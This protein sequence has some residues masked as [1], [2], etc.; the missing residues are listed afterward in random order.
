M[1]AFELAIAQGADGIELDVQRTRDGQLVVIHDETVD[2]TSTG[3]GKV[4]DLTLDELRAF[5]Y[6]NG[7]SGF[8]GVQI[9]TL[10]DVLE[11]VGSSDLTLNIE[12]KNSIELYPGMEESVEAM[13][14]RHDLVERVV[15]S[16]FNHYSLRD[17]RDAGSPLAL[18]LLI[19]DGWV[20]PWRY[21]SEF[22]AS[23]LHPHYLALRDPELVERCHD[24]GIAVNVWTVEPSL[25]DQV[26]ASGVDAIITNSPPPCPPQP[27]EPPTP[28]VP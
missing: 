7:M 17:M 4:V 1:P 6:A 18:G 16:S 25:F 11:L 28:S 2:R 20:G 8:E 13:V 15:V 3:T 22:G 23:A 10:E 12:L 21:A 19:S 27:P 24:S 14:R 5:S 26:T 9:P